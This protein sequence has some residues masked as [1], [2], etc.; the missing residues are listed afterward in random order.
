MLAG[1]VCIKY[2]KQQGVDRVYESI[3]YHT[4]NMISIYSQETLF[5]YPTE[6]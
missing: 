5:I 3:D 6:Y 2:E 4:I 1:P